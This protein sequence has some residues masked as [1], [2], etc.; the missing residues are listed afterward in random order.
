[1]P[2]PGILRTKDGTLEEVKK[3]MKLACAGVA[4]PVKNSQTLTGVKDVYAQYW[5]EELLSRFKE[6]KKDDPKRSNSDIEQ[7]LISWTEANG[8]KIYNPFL[9]TKEFNPTRDTPVEILHTI[10]LG[11]VKY[12]WHVSH[13]PWTDDQKKFYAQRLQSTATDG[14]SIHPIRANY[15][16]QY[17]GSLIGRQFKTIVQ[18]NVFHLRGLVSDLHFN[19]WKAD[20][21]L[22]ALLW[23]P[24][25]RNMAE[26]REDLKVAVANVLDIFA[27]IDPS[28]IITKV[29]YHLLV[30]IEDDVVKL[31][32]LVGVIT[33][34]F[35]SFNAVFRYC[36]IFSNHLAPSRDIATQLG[37][38]EAMKHRLTGGW[39]PAHED[40]EAWQQAGP[41]V[42]HFMEKHPVLQKLLGWSIDKSV[43]HGEVKL[44][45]L[46]RGQK[47]RLAIKFQETVAAQAL[48]FGLY[49]GDSNWFKCRTIVSEYL[50]ECFFGS[51]V[52]AASS[53]HELHARNE[54]AVDID[55]WFLRA[56]TYAA[57]FRRF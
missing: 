29:K 41:G 5:I 19:A 10:L 4:K 27:T 40:D 22:S 39:W 30:H 48:N 26:Y 11:I 24:E 1:M 20:A 54:L 6:M 7:E 44:I 2:E 25:I 28:K 31:G 53:I 33:E 37:N 43:N 23:V 17:A 8:E 57:A 14:L 3:Q 46:P 13:T 9:T 49:A 12:I 38:Q 36:S 50:D 34:I 47:T 21:E 32:P 51:W 18:T 52:F 56:V 45:P 16:M 42:R 55:I 15:I 35:E